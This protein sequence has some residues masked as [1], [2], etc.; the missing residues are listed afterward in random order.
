M[1]S[2]ESEMEQI[3]ALIRSTLGMRPDERALLKAI[4]DKGEET[5][6]DI[7]A[8]LSMPSNRARYLLEGKWE[9][10]GWYLYGVTHDL[11]WL[12]ELGQ[13]AAKLA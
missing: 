12:T 5:V 2:D 4:A 8:R 11:G 1:N 9:R 7:V 10:K 6:R 13:E 3:A